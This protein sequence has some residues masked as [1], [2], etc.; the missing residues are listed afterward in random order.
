MAQILTANRVIIMND[1]VFALGE[2][3]T[4]QFNIDQPVALH[5]AN[6]DIINNQDNALN[7]EHLNESLLNAAQN[8]DLA[9][10]YQLLADGANINAQDEEGRSALT[11]AIWATGNIEITRAL[12]NLKIKVNLLDNQ[13]ESALITAITTG[14]TDSAR[15]LIKAGAN[16]N[17]KTN[18][19]TPLMYVFSTEELGESE[20]LLTP[21]IEAGADINAVNNSGDTALSLAQQYNRTEAINILTAHNYHLNM[22]A[23]FLKTEFADNKLS[24]LNPEEKLSIFSD[25]EKFYQPNIRDP[26]IKKLENDGLNKEK[27]VIMADQVFKHMFEQMYDIL[28]LNKRVSDFRNLKAII[29]NDAQKLSPDL[30]SEVAKYLSRTDHKSMLDIF[31]IK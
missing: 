28:T 17:I 26:L 18:G 2:S 20:E 19:N 4:L 5:D 6:I 9:Q 14:S 31:R 13:G 24:T 27:A 1:E 21:L 25:C 8:D 30:T 12:L 10:I 7:I 15:L 22:I 3:T 11:L 16:V 29:R 23:N